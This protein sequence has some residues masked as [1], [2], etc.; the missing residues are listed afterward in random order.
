[1]LQALQYTK[2]ND[3][4]Q[5]FPSQLDSSHMLNRQNG[6]KSLKTIQL[7]KIEKI[8]KQTS[9]SQTKRCHPT[10]SMSHQDD[11]NQELCKPHVAVFRLICSVTLMWGSRSARQLCR[12]NRLW[13]SYRLSK[14]FPGQRGPRGQSFYS[15]NG[16]NYSFLV[17]L[18]SC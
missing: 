5:C 2:Q 10:C 3:T 12:L 15:W 4:K 6:R 14:L 9:L 13:R 7:Q 1:M 17:L 8:T 11:H 18:F 16:E